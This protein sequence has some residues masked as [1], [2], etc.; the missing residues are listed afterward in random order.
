MSG[1]GV[2]FRPCLRALPE[3]PASLRKRLRSAIRKIIEK[4]VFDNDS[5]DY[6][7]INQYTRRYLTSRQTRECPPYKLQA[8]KSSENSVNCSPQSGRVVWEECAWS[9]VWKL[10]FK[11]KIENWK[12]DSIWFPLD[13]HWISIDFSCVGHRRGSPAPRKSWAC[14]PVV[15]SVRGEK[16]ITLPQRKS[17]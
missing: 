8:R 12:S 6:N 2:C 16:S 11:K 3:L 17:W 4:F 15:C 13:F 7:V 10:D 1:R 14:S 5:K 9:F